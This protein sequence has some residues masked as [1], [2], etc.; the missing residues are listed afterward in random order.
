MSRNTL[1]TSTPARPGVATH[2][3]AGTRVGAG[4]A[5]VTATLC[6]RLRAEPA[7]RGLGWRGG[8]GGWG[9][10]PRAHLQGGSSSGDSRGHRATLTRRPNVR[11]PCSERRPIFRGSHC[12]SPREAAMRRT[13]PGAGSRRAGPP[14]RWLQ[15]SFPPAAHLTATR[16][17]L[18]SAAPNMP[19]AARGSA[20]YRALRA[21]GGGGGGGDGEGG[22]GS[23]PCS[24]HVGRLNGKVAAP[25]RGRGR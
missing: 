7:R 8:S 11:R 17:E 20:R 23:E 18:S 3:I 10:T 5:L 25:R 12:C 9:Q 14:A 21:G 15:L 19:A 16:T 4:G 1:P 6:L 24:S 22:E 13:G 2:A